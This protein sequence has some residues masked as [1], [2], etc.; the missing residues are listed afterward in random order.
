MQILKTLLALKNTE[1]FAYHN[2]EKFCP[3]PRQFLSFVSRRSVLGLDLGIFRVLGREGC[4][5]DSIFGERHLKFF[6][7]VLV[8]SEKLGLNPS[9]KIS[10]FWNLFT[11]VYDQV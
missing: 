7:N 5:L 1:K 8:D 3:W 4:V 9:I 11:A 10:W 6:S 2:L